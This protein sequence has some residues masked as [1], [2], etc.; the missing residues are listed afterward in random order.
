M[1]AIQK[2][3]RFAFVELEGNYFRDGGAVAWFKSKSTEIA[4]FLWICDELNLCA[5]AILSFVL[6]LK[7]TSLEQNPNLQRLLRQEAEHEQSNT[8][9]ELGEGR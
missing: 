1:T 6:K 5:S 8:D 7:S 9:G 2:H 4:S 3:S